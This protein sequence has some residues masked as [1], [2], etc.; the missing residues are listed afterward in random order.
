MNDET[1]D[2]VV[3][4]GGLGG[5]AAASLISR[6][7]LQVLVLERETA[8]RDRVRGEW[9]APW[10]ILELEALGLRDVADA[11]SHVNLITRNVAYDEA[12]TP[13]QAEQAALDI[14]AWIPGGGCLAIG[15]PQFQEA[16]LAN[17]RREGATVRRGANSISVVPGPAP[18]VTYESD[19]TQRTARCRLVVA[20]DGRESA[21]RKSLGIDLNAT[22]AQVIMAGMLV[23]GTRDW[24]ADQQTIG[25]E[26]DFNYLI[27]PQADGRARLYGAWSATDTHRFSGPG[28]EAR[29][30]ESFRLSALPV[31]GAIADATPAGPLAGYPMTDTWT[32]NVAVDGVVLVGDAAGWSDPIIGQGM[33]VTLRDVHMVTDA[34][35]AGSDWSAGA[36]A[37]YADERRERMRRLRFASAGTYVLNGF[38]PEAIAKRRRLGEIFAANPMASP[39]AT[40]LLGAWVLPEEAYSDD[41]WNALVSA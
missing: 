36:F 5:C 11:V 15:H 16:I 8:F 40:A 23:D 31:P 22:D 19:G 28:R 1:F 9:L 4:G 41:A 20:A 18:C 14:A 21:I 38:G 33:S 35:A 25:V 24:P 29:F 6:A 39:A 32:D 37:P 13:E 10:G 30:L 3:V 34:L 17:A 12:V 2:V 7:G 26:G 27:F